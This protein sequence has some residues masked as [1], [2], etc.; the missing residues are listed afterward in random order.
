MHTVGMREL[1][2]R[3]SAYVRLAASGERVLVM[4]RDRI[5]AELTAPRDAPAAAVADPVL[6]DLISRGIA[7][8]PAKSGAPPRLGRGTMKLEELLADL[9]ADRTDR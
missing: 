4:D 9:D 1:R 2:N 5:V 6:E 7:T 8:P 3:L